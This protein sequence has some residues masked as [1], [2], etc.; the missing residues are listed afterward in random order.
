MKIEAGGIRWGDEMEGES[1]GK[2]QELG[3][4]G[5]DVET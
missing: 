2:Q 5:S 3:A 1:S 4:F